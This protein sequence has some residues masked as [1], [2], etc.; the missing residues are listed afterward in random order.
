M[1]AMLTGTAQVHQKLKGRAPACAADLPIS[2]LAAAAIAHW[3]VCVDVVV[4]LSPRNGAS[5]RPAHLYVS[6]G[7]LVC[8]R[9]LWVARCW[10]EDAPAKAAR[11]DWLLPS[12]HPLR[13]AEDALR[14]LRDRPDLVT[15]LDCR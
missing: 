13:C 5:A 6:F 7:A 9:T 14:L 11:V 8:R 12:R 15:G 1:N 3:P 4:N 10:E 2:Q